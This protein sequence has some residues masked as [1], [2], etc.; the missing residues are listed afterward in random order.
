MS[1]YNIELCIF[2]SHS[3]DRFSLVAMEDAWLLRQYVVIAINLCYF[4]SLLMTR[5]RAPFSSFRRWLSA[6]K[7]S[8]A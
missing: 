3:V 7:F 2:S 1:L 6:F 8:M 5:I 4:E